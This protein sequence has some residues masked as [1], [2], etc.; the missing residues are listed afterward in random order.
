M[1]SGCA[2]L[3]SRNAT[4]EGRQLLRAGDY[5]Q[6]EV[7]IRQAIDFAE[8]GGSDE[9]LADALT[10][11]GKVMNRQGRYREA[12]PLMRRAVAIRE[13]E[14]SAGLADSLSKLAASLDGQEKYQEAEALHVRSTELYKKR[15]GEVHPSVASSLNNLA[16]N[17]FLKATINEQRPYFWKPSR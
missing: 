12:E 13:R 9:D 17:S 16:M 11:L 8:Q 1:L 6:G 5:A 7:K 4:D 15:R 3:A 10:Q 14:R 2:G